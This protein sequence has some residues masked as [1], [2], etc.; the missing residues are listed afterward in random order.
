MAQ[1]AVK[2]AKKVAPSKA[3]GKKFNK[4][5]TGKAKMKRIN[6]AIKNKS[7][8]GKFESNM[9]NIVERAAIAKCTRNRENLKLLKASQGRDYTKTKKYGLQ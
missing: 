5:T 1:G 3:N 2:K 6:T 4:S 7:M 9:N 8:K